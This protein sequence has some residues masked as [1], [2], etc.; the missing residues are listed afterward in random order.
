MKKITLLLFVLIGISTL[1]SCGGK[2]EAVQVADVHFFYLEFCPDC[3]DY[4]TAEKISES[5]ELL[6]GSAQNIVSDEDALNLKNILTEKNLADISH[7]LPLLLVEGSYYVG[8]EEIS[9]IVES[10][11]NDQ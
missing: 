11:K 5:V 9:K 10:L 3:E 1:S 8:Y 6:G 7:S 2:E 4:K